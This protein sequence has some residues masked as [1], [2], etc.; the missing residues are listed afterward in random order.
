MK[1]TVDLLINYIREARFN[2][3][4]ISESYHQH[5]DAL[6]L[7]VCV[8]YVNAFQYLAQSYASALREK[9]SR[10][11]S[12]PMEEFNEYTT[13]L[14]SVINDI[15]RVFTDDAICIKELPIQTS[16]SQS[17]EVVRLIEKVVKLFRDVRL[18][19]VDQ[20]SGM[21]YLFA[22]NEE[23]RRSFQA[24]GAI[25]KSY[26]KTLEVTTDTPQP[27]NQSTTRC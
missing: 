23:D 3:E 6:D 13:F 25:L 22:L 21:I 1:D 10:W 12:M 27:I 2:K 8:A 11:N 9:D 15:N 7:K 5:I 19:A 20:L 26:I 4:N 24:P 18:L 14:F 17:E 16:V